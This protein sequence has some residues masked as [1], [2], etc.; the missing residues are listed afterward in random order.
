MFRF[1]HQE[2]L[3][4]LA[5]LPVLMAV[6]AGFVWNKQ[7]SIKKFGDPGILSALMPFASVSRSHYKFILLLLS[8]GFL[9]VAIAGPQFGSKIK[10]IKRKGIEIMIA[11]DV[12]N[13]MMARDIEPNRLERAKQAISKLIDKLENDRLGLIVFAGDAYIQIPMTGDYTSA[14][15]FLSGINTA[16]VSR[17]GTAIGSAI[18][19]GMKSFSPREETNKA[20][21]IISDGEN[22]EGSAVDMARNAAEKGIKVYTIGIGLPEGV[23]IPDS[24]KSYIREY[25]R[26]RNGNI[27]TT[28]LNEQMLN[29]I[30]HAGNGK[31]FRATSGNIGLNDLHTVLNRLDKTEME[32]KT[33]SEYEEQFP[34]IIWIV[35]T[36]LIFELLLLERK[37]KWFTKISIFKQA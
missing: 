16:M 28:R 10:E 17:Q 3:W 7:R 9:I 13:S 32:S 8:F 1:A 34:A 35:L 22:H 5:V 26:D 18:E 27:V 12:S 36:L 21:V 15:M 6:Y 29:E 20:I 11:L 2:Y 33:Y 30:A 24:D 31:Y 19:L 25:R 37:N 23:P 4:L 14:K